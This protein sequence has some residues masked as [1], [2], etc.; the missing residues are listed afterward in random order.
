MAGVGDDLDEVL[1]DVGQDDVGL[2]VGVEVAGDEV[3]EPGLGPVR[4]VAGQR[5]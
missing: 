3:A 2:A 4:L 5:S 1:G